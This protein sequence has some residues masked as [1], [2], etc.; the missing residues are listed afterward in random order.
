MYSCQSQ[1]M[2]GMLLTPKLCT[3][4]NQ[5]VSMECYK[6]LMLCTAVNISVY[7]MLHRINHVVQ[8]Q[9][10]CVQLSINQ[11]CSWNVASIHVVYTLQAQCVYEMLLTSPMFCTAANQSMYISLGGFQEK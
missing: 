8:N 4:V 9:S 11:M 5:N 1:W 2:Y 10:C 3:P 6:V 7:G